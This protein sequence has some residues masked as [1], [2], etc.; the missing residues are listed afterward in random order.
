MPQRMNPPLG[1]VRD[2]YGERPALYIACPHACQFNPD[3]IGENK[4]NDLRRFR[5]TG[6]G[7]TD[8]ARRATDVLGHPVSLSSVQ[9]HMHHYKESAKDNEILLGPK[10]GEKLGDLEI[11]DLVIQR[12]AANS[13]NWKPSIKDTIEAMKLKMQMTGNSAY[14]DLISLFDGAETDELIAPDESPEAVLS[15][16]ERPTEDAEDLEAPLL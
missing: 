5:E 2:R 12:G 8:F 13:L 6:A 3:K 10:P 4:A 16:D 9:R 7:A 11:L 14:D 15:E 1:R